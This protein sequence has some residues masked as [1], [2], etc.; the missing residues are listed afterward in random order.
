MSM[1]ASAVRVYFAKL[2]LEQEIA[3]IYMALY[4]HGPQ[5]IAALSR[6]SGVERTRIYRLIDTLLES[7]LI[8]VDSSHTRGIIKAAPISNLRILINRRNEELKNLTDELEL[9]EQV[10][11]RNSL[12]YG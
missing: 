7:N 8:E 2:G 5:H 6:L 1:D 12:S 10:M 9:L 3:D 11:A 4:A